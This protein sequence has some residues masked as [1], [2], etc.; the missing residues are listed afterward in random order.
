MISID[1]APRIVHFADPAEWAAAQARG[2]YAPRSLAELGFIHL[3]TEAQVPGV[4]ERHLRGGGPRVRLLLDAQ[5]CGD[6]LLWEW[7]ESSADVYP[8]LTV[9]IPLDW[10]IE[11]DAFDPDQH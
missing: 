9:P 4:V 8:H 3:A 6:A 11:A 10:V 7:V 1:A 5:R 2:E